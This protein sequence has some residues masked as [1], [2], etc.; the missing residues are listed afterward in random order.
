MVTLVFFQHTGRDALPSRI[1][2]DD[3]PVA[4]V[5]N[6]VE[7]DSFS[8]LDV[9]VASI[10]V[11]EEGRSLL[12]V[13]GLS[14]GRCEREAFGETDPCAGALVEVDEPSRDVSDADE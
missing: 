9:V 11:A 1:G 10:V 7:V 13:A 2:E 3:E 12:L 6:P 4:I 8:S 5:V 14:L